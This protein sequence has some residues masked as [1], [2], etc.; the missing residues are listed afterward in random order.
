MS[1]A[2]STRKKH[3]DG[4]L[5]CGTPHMKGDSVSPSVY[6]HILARQWLCKLVHYAK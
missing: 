5:L 2:T 6:D 3:L 4:R 1:A